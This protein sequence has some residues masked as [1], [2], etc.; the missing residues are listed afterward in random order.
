LFSYELVVSFDHNL[1]EEKIGEM[2]SK[3][4][5]KIKGFGGEVE[6]VDRWGV[7]KLASMIKKARKLTQAYFVVVFFKG[8]KTIPGKVQSYLKVTEDIIRYSIFKGVPKQEAEIAGKP[9]EKGEVEAVNVGEIK[10]ITPAPP[11]GEDLGK[12]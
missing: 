9:A 2:V 6:K 10:E 11:E 3:I 7:R 8:E 5:A 12:S 1:G 4:E